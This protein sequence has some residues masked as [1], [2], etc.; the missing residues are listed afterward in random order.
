MGLQTFGK[1]TAEDASKRGADLGHQRS[2][3]E[4]EGDKLAGS[5]VLPSFD[6]D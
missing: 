1:R 4:C 3:V 6:I 2:K 5:S